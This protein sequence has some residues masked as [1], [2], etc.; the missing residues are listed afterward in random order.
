MKEY[1]AVVHRLTRRTRGD[2]DAL[3]DLLNERSRTGWELAGMTQ[4]EGRIVLVFSRT[5]QTEE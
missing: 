2:E 3:T 4:D 1:Q 5:A